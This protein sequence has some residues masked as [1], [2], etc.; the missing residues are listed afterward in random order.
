MESNRFD[1]VA[2]QL[3]A[4]LP[5]RRLLQGLAGAALGGSVGL[6]GQ[7]DVGSH[8]LL[9]RCRKIKDGQRRRRCIKHAKQHNRQHSVTPPPP[10][11]TCSAVRQ[12]CTPPGT[13][14]SGICF[15]PGH[16]QHLCGCLGSGQGCLADQQCC[17]GTCNPGTQ[18]CTCHQAG[19]LCT[20]S[21]QCCP[22][23]ACRDQQFI[24]AL[25]VG[26]CQP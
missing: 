25:P 5:R 14:C 9:A 4:G 10:G 19:T 3:V 23:L 26:T 24:G 12:P 2:R 7:E 22:G 16:G 13:C 11:P 21:S 17:S 15:D 1:D 8:N 18:A 20:A 6:L